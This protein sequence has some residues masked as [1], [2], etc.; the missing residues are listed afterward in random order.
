MYKKTI[1]LTSDRRLEQ[2]IKL[3]L[4]MK[5]KEVEN[6]FS[7]LS[8]IKTIERDLQRFQNTVHLRGEFGSFIKRSGLPFMI[9]MDYII[10]FTLPKQIDPDFRKLFRTFL[11]AF[12]ILANGKGYDTAKANIVLI[13][14]RKLESNVARFERDPT[15]FLENLKTQDE[16]VNAIIGSFSREKDRVQSFFNIR[17]I[18]YP[19]DGNYKKEIDSLDRIVDEADSAL[20]KKEREAGLGEVTEMITDDLEPATVICRATQDRIIVNGKPR[21]VSDEEREEFHEKNINLLGAITSKTVKDVCDRI[22]D[23]FTAMDKINPFK[24][25]EKVF[26]NIPDSSI[27]DGSFASS[28]G[29][30][31]NGELRAYTGISINIGKENCSKVR[32]SPGFIAIRD[33]LIKNL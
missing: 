28:M 2:S 8:D 9:I 26:I 1:L 23:T 31:L 25:D 17:H 32:Q 3:L 4:R 21:E 10:D 15:V 5:K 14:D 33:H 11:I 27:L 16:R 18:F 29:S 30:F 19:H 20:I 24:K 13:I 12:T 22:L 7:L 6:K